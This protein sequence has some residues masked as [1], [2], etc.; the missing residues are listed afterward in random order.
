MRSRPTVPEDQ[1]PPFW[2]SNLH[3]GGKK[4]PEWR[5][6]PS[7]VEAEP[8]S[9]RFLILWAPP[10]ASKHSPGGGA[11]RARGSGPLG[12][13]SFF[14]SDRQVNVRSRG[15][16]QNDGRTSILAVEPPFWRSTAKTAVRPP[17]RRSNLHNGGL[18]CRTV[19]MTVYIVATLASK[20]LESPNRCQGHAKKSSRMGEIRFFVC[21]IEH[22]GSHFWSTPAVGKLGHCKQTCVRKQ[23][24]YIHI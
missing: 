8:P 10:S 15:G 19:K 14:F 21:S 16:R 23:R 20:R 4:T 18:K 1:K 22:R 12:V 17:K 13:Q 2:R 9:W 3:S 6:R 11:A 7:R 24:L 5:E